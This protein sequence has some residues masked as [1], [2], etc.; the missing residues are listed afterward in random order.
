MYKEFNKE[1]DKFMFLD[2][3][4][5]RGYFRTN[6]II[7]LFP[8]FNKIIAEYRSIVSD[9]IT[10]NYDIFIYLNTYKFTYCI[11]DQICKTIKSG[12]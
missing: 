11:I 9:Y 10:T 1:F 6:K 7:D 3:K 8:K 12:N 4:F 2:L 5:V